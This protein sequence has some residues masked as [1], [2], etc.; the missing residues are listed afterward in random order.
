MNPFGL[1]EAI[2]FV[3]TSWSLVSD[4]RPSVQSVPLGL[5][6]PESKTQDC[7]WLGR[8]GEEGWHLLS[9]PVGWFLRMCGWVVTGLVL[10]RRSCGLVTRR[11]QV[12]ERDWAAVCCLQTLHLTHSAELWPRFLRFALW[13][14]RV[15]KVHA[16][17]PPCPWSA[18]PQTWLLASLEGCG[19]C[20]WDWGW[21]PRGLHLK[22]R[23][24]F[25][26]VLCFTVKKI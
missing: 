7:S 8:S 15:P 1:N 17:S 2:V 25:C 6:Y 10:R 21:V 12:H 16:W 24:S 20:G 13:G 14:S 5:F 11:R 9:E 23:S 22:C 19:P 18:G 3:S 26:S 4:H